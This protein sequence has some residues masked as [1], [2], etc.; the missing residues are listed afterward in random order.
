MSSRANTRRY[1]RA[2]LFFPGDKTFGV[3][4]TAKIM[5][6]PAEILTGNTV[7]VMWGTL[8]IIKASILFLHGKYHFF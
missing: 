3:M 7:K 8:G 1:Q 2:A 4:D 6:T 5:A